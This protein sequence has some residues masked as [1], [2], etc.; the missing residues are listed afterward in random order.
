MEPAHFTLYPALCPAGYVLV[1]TG[2][3]QGGLECQCEQNSQ[4]IINCEDDQDK[5]LIEVTKMDCI[6]RDFVK[7]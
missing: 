3:Q 4:L 7:L 2:R 5:V 6:A 1:P